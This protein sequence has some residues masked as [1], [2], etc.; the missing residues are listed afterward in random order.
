MLG[1]IAAIVLAL[2]IIGGTNAVVNTNTNAD[3][4]QT[5]TSQ[6]VK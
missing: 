5:E 2:G 4:N 3:T 6:F 1:T